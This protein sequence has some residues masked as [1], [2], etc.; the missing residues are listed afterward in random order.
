MH[1]ARWNSISRIKLIDVSPSYSQPASRPTI[2]S[3]HP[4]IQPSSRPV[5]GGG[6]WPAGRPSALRLLTAENRHLRRSA[7]IHKVVLRRSSQATT[8]TT[9]TIIISNS[10]SNS[11]G[12]SAKGSRCPQQ[13]QLRLRRDTAWSFARTSHCRAAVDNATSNLS[14]FHLASPPFT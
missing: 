6:N 11:S 13:E 14:S 8:T 7:S 9:T 1:I 2:P 10:S 3:G 12:S 5:G 4:A